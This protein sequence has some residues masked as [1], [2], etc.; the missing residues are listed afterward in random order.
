MQIQKLNNWIKNQKKLNKMN[1]YKVDFQS[2]EG[3][4]ISPSEIYNKKK[5]FF[6]IKPYKFKNQNNKIWFQ[7]LI[8]QKEV[9]I[10]GIIKKKVKNLDYYLL[11]A[12]VEPGNI[13]NIQLSPTVQATK[14]NY[15]RAHGG[16]KTKYL[17]YFIRKN[18]NSKILTNL[19]LSEQGTRYF[20]KS[21]KNILVE[22]KNHKIKNYQNFIWLSKKDL[23]YL[24]KK[25]NLLNMDSISVFSSSI[26]KEKIDNP[27]N[28]FS[29][30]KRKYKNLYRKLHI[31]KKNISFKDM[32]GWEILK[33]RIYDKNKRFFS[34]IPLKV[35]SNSREVSSWSQP[36]I[37]DH[38][39]SFNGFLCK[40]TNETDHYLLKCVLEPGFKKPKFTSTVAIKNYSYTKKDE[41]YLSFFEGKKNILLDVINSDEGGRFFKNETRN[42]ITF[43]KR[44]KKL[45]I[46]KEYIWASHN[47]VVDLINENLLSIEARNL[48][49]SFNIEKIK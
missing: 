26:K 15:L 45:T 8:I 1:I 22:I 24:I 44:E 30:I 4:Q 43:L 11:Q 18:N 20:E 6:S 39:S 5:K 27:I 29:E 41:K 14:S 12:K 7:P 42:M 34:I 19:R 37:S 9:G 21:N 46:S 2:T 38:S 49:A 36:I 40:K 48:F 32:K 31:I 3:W 13:D 17:Q 28:K 10:L 47:Q 35:E 25:K 16:K 23:I 33:K